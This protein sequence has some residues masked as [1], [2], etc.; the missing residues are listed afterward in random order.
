M[1]PATMQRFYDAYAKFYD[2]SYGLVLGPRLRNAMQLLRLEPGMR[3]LDLGCGTGLSLARYPRD[4]EVVGVDLS[5]GMLRE[6][7]RRLDKLGISNVELLQGNAEALPFPDDHFDAIFI[8]HVL[9]VVDDPERVLE[10]ARRVCRPGGAVVVINRFRSENRAL[11]ALERAL[12]PIFLKLGWRAD[13]DV[14]RVTGA[15]GLRLVARSRLMRN[16]LWDALRLVVDKPAQTKEK[17]RRQQ[18]RPTA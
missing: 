16:D 14:G 10:Q 1:Q 3:V 4:V 9:T 2:T 7:R 17:S 6:A 8:S 18:A 15:E 11:A 12:N 5:A 13:L